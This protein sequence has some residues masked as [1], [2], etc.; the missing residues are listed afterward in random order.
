M[1]QQVQIG[2]HFEKYMEKKSDYHYGFSDYGRCGWLFE[3]YG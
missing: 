2:G 3:F 1:Y